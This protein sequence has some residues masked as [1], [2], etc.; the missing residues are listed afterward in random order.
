MA[1]IHIGS[2]YTFI[3]MIYLAY[4]R[5]ENLGSKIDDHATKVRS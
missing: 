2:K 1:H 3:N 5:V 4:T